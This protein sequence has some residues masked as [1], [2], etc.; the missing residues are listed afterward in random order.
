MGEVNDLEELLAALAEE[1]RMPIQQNPDIGTRIQ[2]P[3]DVAQFQ[4]GSSLVGLTDDIGFAIQD[5]GGMR[6]NQ[7]GQFA[8]NQIAQ[9][10]PQGKSVFVSKEGSFIIMMS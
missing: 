6:L 10:V 8:S 9:S 3:H 7:N 2:Q 5:H 4:G 1:S